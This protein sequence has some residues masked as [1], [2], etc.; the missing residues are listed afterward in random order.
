MSQTLKLYI[1]KV[2]SE[3]KIVLLK[4]IGTLQMNYRAAEIDLDAG[5]LD[6]PREEI[7]FIPSNERKL[8]PVL[9]RVVEIIARVDEDEAA[10]LVENFMGDLQGEL[11]LNGF[12]TFPN[13]GW[14]KQDHWGSLF[15]EPAAEYISINRFFGFKK[16]KLPEAISP[17]EQE[18]IADLKETVAER[19]EQDSLVLH[20]SGSRNWGFI[21][22][23]GLML[24]MFLCLS[25]L[26]KPSNDLNPL[27]ELSNLDE[28]IA[29]KTSVDH[30]RRGA[31]ESGSTTDVQADH[32]GPKEDEVFGLTRQPSS[33]DDEVQIETSQQDSLENG[34]IAEP[35]SEDAQC[36]V[37]VGAFRENNNVD[38]M[39]DRLA[40]AD[41]ESVVIEGP[42]LTK[43]GLRYTCD[44]DPRNTLAWAQKNIDEGA[45]LYKMD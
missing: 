13:I 23:I 12:L 33:I 34:L 43:V 29:V 25:F 36:I 44:D 22:G 31:P 2:L 3:N 42:K 5:T 27:A 17:A 21:I 39:I 10:D 37:I 45:W 7:F 9:I 19:A 30:H 14:I 40:T 41:F 16:V 1:P 6:A 20:G 15:F 24:M 4:G 38:R 28:K 26:L 18:V 11:A 8:D 32:Q 35:S